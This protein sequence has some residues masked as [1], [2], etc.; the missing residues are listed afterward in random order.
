MI[1]P[2]AFILFFVSTLCVKVQDLP[3]IDQVPKRIQDK[4]I[5]INP[6][7]IDSITYYGA[8]KIFFTN[9]F[10]V[11]VSKIIIYVDGR[12]YKTIG[13]KNHKVYNKLKRY[14]NEKKIE[15]IEIFF[16]E[17]YPPNI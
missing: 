10:N 12:F 15:Q 2:I 1:K 9:E 14:L 8:Y 11:K 5:S 7:V 6:I 3:K 16:G 13:K 4:I 17:R